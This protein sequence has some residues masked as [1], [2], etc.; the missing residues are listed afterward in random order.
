MNDKSSRRPDSKPKKAFSARSRT[1]SSVSTTLGKP[2]PTRADDR[3][4]DYGRYTTVSPVSQAKPPTAN[5]SKTIAP[6]L[7]QL[8]AQEAEIAV[9][10]KRLA[11][12]EAAQKVQVNA[13]HV[14]QSLAE[15]SPRR[16]PPA[17]MTGMGMIM[18]QLDAEETAEELLAQLK[19]L[20]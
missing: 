20:D 15:L 10:K 4:D 6:I 5:L 17:G 18:G 12:M 13:Y 19:A 9:L 16:L 8:K 7:A 3:A 2:L 14:P 11:Q 1:K